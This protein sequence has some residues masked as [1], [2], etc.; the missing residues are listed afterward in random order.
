MRLNTTPIPAPEAVKELRAM[1]AQILSGNG[2]NLFGRIADLIERLE[3][4]QLPQPIKELEG[5]VP[6][7]VWFEKDEHRDEFIEGMRRIYPGME[8]RKL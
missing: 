6:V 7:V 3:K 1:Q 2:N 4:N 5:A 8:A